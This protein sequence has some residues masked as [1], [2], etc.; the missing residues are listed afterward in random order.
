MRRLGLEQLVAHDA[1]VARVG[2][3]AANA[4]P[5]STSMAMPFSACM[6]ISPP[7]SAPFWKARSTWPSSL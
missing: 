2:L 1:V 7:V 3:A 5:M 4:C 6:R